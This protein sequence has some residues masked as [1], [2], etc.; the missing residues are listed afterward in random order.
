MKKAYWLSLI[1]LGSCLSVSAQTTQN[2][3]WID[4]PK[5]TGERFQIPP[6]NTYEIIKNETGKPVSHDVLRSI[7]RRRL[8]NDDVLWRVNSELE[9]LVYSKKRVVSNLKKNP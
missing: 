8:S 6:N 4:S 2:P 1:L 7:H 3:N 5:R 9:I